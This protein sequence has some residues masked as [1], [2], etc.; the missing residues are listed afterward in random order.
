MFLTVDNNIVGKPTA[1]VE[2]Q[3]RAEARTAE[4]EEQ[5]KQRVKQLQEGR[6]AK[7]GK[8]KLDATVKAYIEELE[9]QLAQAQ[10]Q[11]AVKAKDTAPSSSSN[12]DYQQASPNKQPTE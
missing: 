4:V 7:L 6:T 3:L 10:A 11:L 1:T 8:K 5:Q 2:Q 9:Q 12:S